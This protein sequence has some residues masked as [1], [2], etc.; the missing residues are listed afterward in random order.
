MSFSDFFNTQDI[1]QKIGEKARKE[2]KVIENNDLNS[3]KLE[4]RDKFANRIFY[5]TV[6]YLVVIL[7][8]IIAN[9][10][11][12]VISFQIE[13][14]VIYTLLGSVMLNYIG[15]LTLI[16]QSIYSEESFRVYDT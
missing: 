9:G 5:L 14:G 1:P 8:L 4:H 6:G 7:L 3:Q 2:K 15:L 11:S 13:S 12:K 16:L 10:F